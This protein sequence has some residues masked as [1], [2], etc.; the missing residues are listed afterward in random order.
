MVTNRT[1]ASEIVGA[2]GT[3]L[4]SAR[5][6]SAAVQQAV[7]TEVM[8]RVALV[9]LVPVPAAKNKLAAAR[10]PPVSTC[11]RRAAPGFGARILA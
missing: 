7:M 11:L 2:A 3:V 4:S 5:F 6:S 10:A 8:T 9:S 1:V